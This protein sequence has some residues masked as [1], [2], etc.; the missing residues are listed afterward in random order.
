MAR[1]ANS[2]LI[3]RPVRKNESEQPAPIA[4]AKK[5]EAFTYFAPS[6]ENVLLVGDFTAWEQHPIS[7]RKQKMA[8]GRRSF[9]W[10]P[11][12]TN[13]VSWLMG[14]GRTMSSATNESP[15]ASARRTAF[16]TSGNRCPIFGWQ[17]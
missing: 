7:L 2:M 13:T 11:E 6:A 3:D 4:E 1:T 12:A 14:N 15:M 5:K 17:S 8:G 10:T 9:R 16:A